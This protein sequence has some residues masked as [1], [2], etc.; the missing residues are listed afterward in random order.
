MKKILFCWPVF[1][2][3][4]S[5][6]F[7]SQTY[8]NPWQQFIEKLWEYGRLAAFQTIREPTG[9]LIFRLF[10]TNWRTIIH[11]RYQ[12]SNQE[13]ICSMET[14]IFMKTMELNA[15]AQNPSDAQFSINNI[16]PPIHSKYYLRPPVYKRK[17]FKRFF[18]SN[19]TLNLHRILK[20][21]KEIDNLILATYILNITSCKCCRAPVFR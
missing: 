19:E 10:V 9:I 7:L 20:I 16:L 17:F 11:G 14:T 12:V 4:Y 13:N 18:Q 5:K 3:E 2:W 1:Q 21:F 6:L 15:K 8:Q